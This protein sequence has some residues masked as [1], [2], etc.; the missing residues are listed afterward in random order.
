MSTEAAVK[1]LKYLKDFQQN[2][3]FLAMAQITSRLEV[4]MTFRML[5]AMEE[6]SMRFSSDRVAL[7][8]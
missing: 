7:A 3:W 8:A 5:S 6:A 2:D 1:Y 4:A